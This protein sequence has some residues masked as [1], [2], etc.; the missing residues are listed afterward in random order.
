MTRRFLENLERWTRQLADSRGKKV[1]FLSHCL[2]NENTRYLGGACEAGAVTCVVQECIDQGWGIV[3]MPC[4]EEQA[5]GGVLKR[6]LIHAFG[7]EGTLLYRSRE[8]VLPLLAWYT[9][10]VCR[11]L[12]R[13]AVK[14]IHDYIRSGFVV[15]GIVGVDGSPSCGVRRTLNLRQSLQLV[16]S[17]PPEATREDMNSIVLRCLAEGQGFF[18][19]ELQEELS[20]RRLSV[21]LLAF[22]MPAELRGRPVSRLQGDA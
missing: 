9:R 17:L 7:S 13:Q 11:R 3:Q 14:Q 16:G 19:E 6:R 12:A 1:I 18:I 22:D 8:I 5:W 20:R 10:R 21:P 4:P 2:L 15:A